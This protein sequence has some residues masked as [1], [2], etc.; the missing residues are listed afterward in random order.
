MCLFTMQVAAGPPLSGMVS[1][2][3]VTAK[4]VFV[5]G[6]GS[7]ATF[8]SASNVGESSVASAST[9]AAKPVL[10]FCVGEIGIMQL[11]PLGSF[12]NPEPVHCCL[13]CVPPP[14]QRN[15]ATAPITTV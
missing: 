11:R 3:M 10:Q 13:G 9:F 15:V 4:S 6:R 14:A 2:W 8:V 5:P 12:A 1:D 7:K